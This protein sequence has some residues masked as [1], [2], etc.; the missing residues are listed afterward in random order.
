MFVART[1]D[2][3]NTWT[4]LR[5]GLPQENAYDITF[6]HAMHIDDGNRLAF[7]TTGGNLYL[8]DNRGDSWDLYRARI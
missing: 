6:R 4:E 5:N 2:G 3:G 7:G 8:S 1:E